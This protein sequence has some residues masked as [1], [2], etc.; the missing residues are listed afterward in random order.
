MPKSFNQ[1]M[2][3]LALIDIFNEF[4]DENHGL[5]LEQIQQKLSE[6]EIKADR[7]TLY[8]D[9]DNLEDYGL[10]I[11][12]GNEGRTTIY[13]LASRPF[14][15][16]ELKLLVDSVQSA[17]F[18]SEHKS[19]ALI[20]KLSSPAMV[21]KYQADG[22]KR[23]VFM[24]GRVKSMN[25]SILLSI[26]KIHEAIKSGK[27]I[28]FQ[29]FQWNAKKQVELKHNG[30]P[31]YVSPWA[32]IWDNENYYLVAFDSG[33]QKVKHYR[34]DKMKNMRIVDKIQEGLEQ[35]RSFN[36]AEYSQAAFGMY[37]GERV[38]VTLEADKNLVGVIIDRFGK[39][40]SI[41][42]RS[43]NKVEAWVEIMLSPQFLGWVTGFGSGMRI[44]KPQ[45]AVDAMKDLIKELADMYDK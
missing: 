2:R 41:Y 40:V 22:L 6:K 26:D 28:Y 9:F 30:E 34:V 10:D 32:L 11:V 38:S 7:K 31:Y 18:I 3:L 1:K 14:E 33:A 21:S 4:T 19:Q 35:K 23:Q 25:E 5:S 13:S 27:Q 45:K 12:K 17:K 42:E 20:K 44:V 8:V 39:D 36:V 16:A 15:L 37:G 43:N 24:S 29:Y